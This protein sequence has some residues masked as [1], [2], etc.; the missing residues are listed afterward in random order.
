MFLKALDTVE[1]E[2]FLSFMLTYF[3]FIRK[4]KNISNAVNLQR[5]KKKHILKDVAIRYECQL[6]S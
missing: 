5:K 6:L 2:N 3:F 1:H 4:I